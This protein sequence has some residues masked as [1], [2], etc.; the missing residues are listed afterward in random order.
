MSLLET[1]HVYYELYLLVSMLMMV[2][3]YYEL[4]S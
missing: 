4:Y 1:V 2:D 3:V